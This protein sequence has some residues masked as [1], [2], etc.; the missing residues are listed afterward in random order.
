MSHILPAGY[1]LSFDKENLVWH[2]DESYIE[3]VHKHRVLNMET[4]IN[5]KLT[6]PPVSE[7]FHELQSL[8]L[9]SD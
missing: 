3:D 5:N 8:L 4:A 6:I 9:Q 2:N 7:R 1:T